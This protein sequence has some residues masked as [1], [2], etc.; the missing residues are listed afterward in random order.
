MS[1]DDIKS[2]RKA[3]EA[4]KNDSKLNELEELLGHFN[5]FEAI[6]II[7]Q[8]IRHSN[9]LAFLLDPKQN[10]GLKDE[11]AKKLFHEL[12]LRYS[13]ER[14]QGLR[15]STD[16]KNIEV[17]REWEDID[18]LLIEE[19]QEFAVIIENKIGSG[20][21][22]DGSDGGQLEKYWKIVED[23]YRKFKVIGLYLSPDGSKP[24]HNSYLPIGYKLIGKTIKELINNA[25]NGELKILMRH[26]T[27]MLERHIM[28]DPE[29]GSLCQRIYDEHRLAVK[30]IF[31]NQGFAE[32]ETAKFLQG[33]IVQNGILVED[34]SDH[35]KDVKTIR[36]FPKE[37]DASDFK[38][39]PKWTKTK[40]ILLFEF[41]V[42]RE[43][44]EL[45][46]TLGPGNPADANNIRGKVLEMAKG[47]G[48]PFEE[49]SK[50]KDYSIIFCKTFLNQEDCEKS[51]EFRESQIQRAWNEFI[52]DDLP[53]IIQ[54]IKRQPW[55]K[56][57]M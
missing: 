12:C 15:D 52:R 5:I 27:R 1:G 30:T 38:I 3:L 28:N 13:Q 44:L 39:C 50:P 25:T 45:G 29:I 9:F 54:V 22:K 41:W 36:F 48:A 16:F 4:F 20:E 35:G 47:A 14:L 34:Q 7:R 49:I 11:F 24:S 17:K 2:I 46:L 23:N 19:K 18:I 21:R 6:G 42:K 56:S 51:W 40:R 43:S 32:E 8:E 55:F 57:P 33:L 53:K 31:K 10:H 37:L 26:Y